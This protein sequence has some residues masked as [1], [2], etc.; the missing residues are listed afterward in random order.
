MGVLLGLS[1]R[2]V[3]FP[4]E[5][6]AEKV[7]VEL[8]R[9]DGEKIW[10]AHFPL[11]RNRID[12]FGAA[13]VKEFIGETVE[14]RGDVE[15]ECLLRVQQQDDLPRQ[16]QAHRPRLHYTAPWGWIND[17][18]GLVVH[19]GICHL[20]HQFNPFDVEWGNMS[21][22][23]STSSD[24][25]H[26]KGFSIAMAP[27]EQGTMFSGCCV[28]D[29]HNVAGFGKDALLFFYTAAGDTNLWS[30]NRNY[31]QCLA[32]SLDGGG[33]LLKTGGA[34]LDTVEPE[35]RDPKIFYHGPSGAY[36]MV[37]YLAGNEF[38]VYRSKD[39]RHWTMSQ[40]LCLP[41][42]WECPDL[43]ELAVDGNPED[44]RWVFWSA[45]GFYFVGSFDGYRFEPQIS[46]KCAYRDRLPYAA[47]TF[48][49]TG[50]RVISM[51]WLRLP[52]M[53]KNYTG[54]MSIPAEV[55]L[56]STKQGPR[57]QLQPVKELESCRGNCVA[58]RKVERDQHLA[59][60]D[61]SAFELLV[62]AAPG[63]KGS[64]E[65]QLLETELCLNFEEGKGFFQGISF[66]LDPRKGL[67][68]RLI[69][70]FDVAELIIAEKRIYLPC[71]NPV[72]SLSGEISVRLRDGAQLQEIMVYTLG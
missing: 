12:F 40:R 29:T 27:D 36:I 16:E 28:T 71:A 49:G 38:A 58:M 1:K 41:K 45:D 48:Y 5:K 33:T 57:L 25:I 24:F 21:W 55:S 66:P 10:E 51:A 6:G 54:A 2:Y 56:V 23:H 15:E 67:F 62:T 64:A 20:Y 22:G 68:I 14:L 44:K 4:V 7:L 35:N 17:P 19:H 31:V 50:E 60:I 47:Q 32:Y 42:A 70:D 59:D 39:L 65:F 43:F 3:W 30:C 37:L 9:P 52:N 69:F 72:S 46:R 13:D 11:A 18:N 26:W 34:V 63:T 53:G 8:F 61:D